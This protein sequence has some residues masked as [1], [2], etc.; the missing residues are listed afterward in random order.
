[1][2][3][4]RLGGHRSRAHLTLRGKN[5]A[6][7]SQHNGD[8]SIWRAK[9]LLSRDQDRAYEEIPGS[10]DTRPSIHEKT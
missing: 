9:L 5:L 6:L 1:M 4:S 7:H 8:W 2:N 3:R 10:A